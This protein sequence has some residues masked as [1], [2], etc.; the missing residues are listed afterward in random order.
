M[1]RIKMIAGIIL[2]MGAVLVFT[3]TRGDAVSLQE[4]IA[5]QVIRLHV[6]A[7]SDVETDQTLKLTVKDAV[8]TK[9]RSKLKN[10][11]NHEQARKIIEENLGE[12]EQEARHVMKEQGYDYTA[13]AILGDA[14]FPVKQYG[15]LT[16]PAGEYEALRINIGKAEGKN[17][18]CVMYPTLCFVD[19][20]YQVVPEESKEVL[21]NELTQDEYEMLVQG[22][23]KVS[24][25]FKFLDW[26]EKIVG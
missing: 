19:S 13:K 17:W 24:Y 3:Y 1:K 26:L 7:N 8:V 23:E 18:W 12:I 4:G 5:S 2:V 6:V 9:L 14:V 15:D 21:K 22:G 20:T 11:E 25:G 10:A 16:F